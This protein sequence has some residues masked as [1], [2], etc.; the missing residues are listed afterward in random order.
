MTTDAAVPPVSDV[1]CDIDG[2]VVTIEVC[3]P[4][5]NYLDAALIA[6]I[7]DALERCEADGSARV[8]VL[9]SQG[10]HFSAGA[11]LG[12]RTEPAEPAT[13]PT[14]HLYDE[15]IRLFRCGLPIVAATQGASIGGGLGLAMAADFRVCGPS[16]RFTANFTRLGFHHGFGLSV[17]LPRAVG[18][19]QA[20]RMILGSER[21]DG[22]EAHRIGLADELVADD[23]IRVAAV[24][25]ARRLAQ[26]APLALRSVRSTLR[27]DLADEVARALEHE[28]AEQDRLSATADFREGV[29]AMAERRD[30]HFTGE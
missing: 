8:A 18:T 17:T 14:R 6:G 28:R 29:A 24:A 3:R 4:P 22:A 12:A 30:P 9:C 11:A 13:A 27:G 10:K 7:A 23:E 16:S 26:N 5:N 19:Q 15:A 20:L 25:M 1:R 21:I 2:D